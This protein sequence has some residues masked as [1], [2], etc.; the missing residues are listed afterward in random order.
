MAVMTV[1]GFVGAVGDVLV[2]VDTE[3]LSICGLVLCGRIL[4]F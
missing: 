3:G 1:R 2:V 4:Y